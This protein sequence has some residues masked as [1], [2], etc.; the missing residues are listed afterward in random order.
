MWDKKFCLYIL[1]FFQKCCLN[2]NESNNNKLNLIM[3][4]FKS[5]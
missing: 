1:F 5:I 3:M 4:K 2:Y